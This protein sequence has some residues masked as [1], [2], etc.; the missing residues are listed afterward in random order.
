MAKH[1]ICFWTHLLTGTKL[2]WEQD[3]ANVFVHK[4]KRE[5]ER[6]VLVFSWICVHVFL[7]GNDSVMCSPI[8]HWYTTQPLLSHRYSNT[9][10]RGRKHMET[11][12][13]ELILSTKQSVSTLYDYSFVVTGSLSGLCHFSSALQVKETSSGITWPLFLGYTH[14]KVSM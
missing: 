7:C 6:D 1:V 2:L 5:W 11:H 4:R 10:V 14:T 9:N 3:W 12:F 13:G 8:H